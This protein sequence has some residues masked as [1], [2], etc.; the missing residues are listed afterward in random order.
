MRGIV[1]VKDVKV[2]GGGTI[3]ARGGLTAK[4]LSLYNNPIIHTIDKIYGSGSVI[5]S[6][7]NYFEIANTGTCSPDA[8]IVRGFRLEYLYI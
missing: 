2:R 4:A 5:F 7:S 3:N 1:T 8:F 6:G